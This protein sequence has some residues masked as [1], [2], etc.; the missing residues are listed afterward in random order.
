MSFSSGM[1]TPLASRGSAE[2]H[3]DAAPTPLRN[4]LQSLP[5]H[6]RGGTTG[7][8]PA[9]FRVTG[10]KLI[11]LVYVPHT[12]LQPRIELGPDGLQPSALPIEP[13][14][15]FANLRLDNRC[16][17]A[18]HETPNLAATFAI[19]VVLISA[20]RFKSGGHSTRSAYF[21]LQA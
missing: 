5:T 21:A 2:Q 9:F 4:H 10:D 20:T 17:T 12:M 11:Q 8:E 15:R 1:A 7:F 14:E 18:V 3:C 13:S 19:D 6:Q 16:F